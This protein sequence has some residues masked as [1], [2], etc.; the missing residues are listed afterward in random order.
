MTS[1]SKAGFFR[2]SW[3]A[4]YPDAE[5]YLS[6]LYSKNFAPTGPNYTHFKNEKFDKLYESAFKETD[7]EK[8]YE[9]YREMD[10][11]IME[12][13]PVI[14]LFYDKVAR[15]SRKEVQNLGINGLNMLDLKR[16]K[17]VKK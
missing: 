6:L 2:G 11:L 15:F 17:K 4:D 13:A 3:I 7:V 14:P 10:K 8:R 16:V 5:N 12:E 1:S 9:L